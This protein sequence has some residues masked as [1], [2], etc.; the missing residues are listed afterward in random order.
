MEAGRLGNHLRARRIA[1][2]L[3]Q[4]EL[5][6][7]AGISRQTLGSLESGETVPATS[8]ALALARALG[9]RVEDLFWLGHDDAPFEAVLV[10]NGHPTL[11]PAPHPSARR[12]AVA[13]VA[14]RWVAHALD[15]GANADADGGT[16]AA[17]FLV[18]ADGVLL[19]ERV[20]R[21]RKGRARVRPLRDTALL[22][23]NVLAA[24]CDPA[25]GLLGGHQRPELDV[26]HRLRESIDP[27]PIASGPGPH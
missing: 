24:G 21:A 26:G 9:C 5:A 10:P 1:A 23:Q 18:P 13:A 6:D 15:G 19:D 27:R 11:R 20:S 8:I 12:V 14:E 22:R 4:R 3:Q 16:G 2:G 17:S 25:L 7:R